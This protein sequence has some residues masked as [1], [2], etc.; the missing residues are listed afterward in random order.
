[1]SYA[2]ELE[3]FLKK[4]KPYLKNGI[5]YQTGETFKTAF[6][7]FT[8]EKTYEMFREEL[9]RF[10]THTPG[11]DGIFLIQGFMCRNGVILDLCDYE[12]MLRWFEVQRPGVL[13]VEE[14]WSSLC[15]VRIEHDVWAGKRVEVREG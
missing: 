5:H 4:V 7:R 2:S 10:Y 11:S 12:D 15:T 1:M 8:S 3:D 13:G 6:I 9:D 14:E